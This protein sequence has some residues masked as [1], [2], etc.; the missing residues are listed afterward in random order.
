MTRNT[1]VSRVLLGLVGGL[2][3][4]AVKASAQAPDMIL[5]NG[6]IVTV[7]SNDTI[8]QA[9]AITGNKIAATGTTEAIQ[10]MAGPNTQKLDLKGRTVIPGIIDTHRHMYGAAEGQYGGALSDDDLRRYPVD[11]AGVKSKED[12]L[13]QVRGVFAKYKKEF[14]PGRWVYLNNRVSFMGNNDPNGSSFAKILYDELN[15]EELNKVTP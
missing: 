15:A 10:A 12:V 14:T 3:L 7:D 4:L 13:N 11:W 9:V 1:V 8:V 6:K 2:M 5:Y